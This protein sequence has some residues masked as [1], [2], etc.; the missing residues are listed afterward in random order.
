MLRSTHRYR[1]GMSEFDYA[2]CSKPF[3]SQDGT[4]AF[5]QA[6][7]FDGWILARAD[8]TFTAVCPTYPDGYYPDAVVVEAIP[9][10]AVPA[11]TA[12]PT[13]ERPHP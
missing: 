10:G 3:M 6:R 1:E 4:R 8:G 11:R 5:M 12:L 13:V 7:A 9:A 2:K